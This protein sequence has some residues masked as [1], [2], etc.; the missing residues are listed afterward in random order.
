MV[1]VYKENAVNTKSFKAVWVARVAVLLLAGGMI[2][3]NAHTAEASSSNLSQENASQRI[4]DTCRDLLSGDKDKISLDFQEVDIQNIF[5]IISDVS[6]L[7]VVLSPDV[8]GTLNV[9]MIDV[10]WNTALNLILENHDLGR[11]CQ[12]DIIRIAPKATLAAAQELEPLSTEMI[13]ISY[14]DLDE[15]VANL[16]GIKSGERATITSD[17]RT[18]TLI[19]SDIP[20]KVR[21]MISIIKTLDVRTPQ[22][23]I[24][25]RIVEVA[26]NYVKELG[27]RWSGF[28]QKRNFNKNAFPGIVRTGGTSPLGLETVRFKGPIDL[29]QPLHP[30]DLSDATIVD[31]GVPSGSPTGAIGILLATSNLDH[32]LDLE[33]QALEEQGKSRTLASPRV[34]TLDNKEAVINSGERRPFLTESA[35]GI[36]TEFV[37]ADIRL[38]VTPHITAKEDIYL[39]IVAQQDAFDF[40]NT[41]GGLPTI[42]TKEASTEVLVANGATTVLGGL[43]QKETTESQGSVPYLS[44]IPFLGYL[45]RNSSETDDVVELLIFVTPTIVREY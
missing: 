17:V 27:V 34:T 16:E 2:I 23:T 11:E 43:Y 30:L 40:S 19:L 13:R 33:L 45:F 3:S 15:M 44:K 32:I 22:V 10:G 36:K 37:D 38:T 28:T 9:R 31:L 14:A 41:S 5:R 1:P 39:K 42:T 25:A 18:N 20:A 6:E 7:N 26:R 8:S 21:E 29:A 12:Q 35:E 4:S 24:E